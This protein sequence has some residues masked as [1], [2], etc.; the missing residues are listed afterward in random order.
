MAVNIAQ[1]NPV[2]AKT[3]ANCHAQQETVLNVPTG[4]GPVVK[5]ALHSQHLTL[6]VLDVGGR[7][8]TQNSP[9]LWA[10]HLL[11]IGVVSSLTLTWTDFGVVPFSRSMATVH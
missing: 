8:L 10:S 3:K 7:K 6:R 9:S 5:T 1:A 2:K 11:W 4:S